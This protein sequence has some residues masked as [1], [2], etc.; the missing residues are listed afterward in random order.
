MLKKLGE[1]YLEVKHAPRRVNEQIHEQFYEEPQTDQTHETEY[2]QHPRV[3]LL[4]PLVTYLQL[5][6]I[7]DPDF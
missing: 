3:L 7:H 1:A 5:K 2:G 6:D 4:P